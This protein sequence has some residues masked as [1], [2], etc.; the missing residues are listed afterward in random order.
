M[1]KVMN[2]LPKPQWAG[3]RRE[4][5]GD[6][7]AVHW[8]ARH[9]L[10]ATPGALQLVGERLRERR[11]ARVGAYVA[12]INLLVLVVIGILLLSDS[13]GLLEDRRIP[14][15]FVGLAPLIVINIAC[16]VGVRRLVWRRWDRRLAERLRMRLAPVGQ[17]DWY[18]LVGRRAVLRAAALLAAGVAYAGWL[19]VDRG[20][21][22]AG[23]AAFLVAAAA[24]HSVALL[25]VAR[26]RP[27]IAGDVEALAIDDRLRGE[28]AGSPAADGLGWIAVMPVVALD[29]PLSFLF[30]LGYLY[31]AAGVWHRYAYVTGADG[32]VVPNPEA[33]R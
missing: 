3:A 2:R 4:L 12:R 26:R 7:N 18:D 11:V 17:P 10:P 9:R 16:D 30:M 1:S 21:I 5:V 27:V 28:E 8:L 33:A 20:P 25:E 31:T 29:D 24:I 32:V 19:W 6:E 13:G 14:L 22:S 23:A 15:G